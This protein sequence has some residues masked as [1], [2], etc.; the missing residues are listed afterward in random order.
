M[1][2]NSVLIVALLGLM[3]IP[4]YAQQSKSSVPDT[5]AC[6]STFAFG[7]GLTYLSFCVTA[8]GNV[9]YLTSP[10]GYQHFGGTEGYSLCDAGTGNVYWDYAAHGDDAAWGAPTVTQPN[11]P[12]TFPLT[13]KR[14]TV[15]GIFTLTQKFTWNTAEHIVAVS[16]TVKNNL[17]VTKNLY[18]TR[19]TDADI[20]NCSNSCHSYFMSNDQ[21]DMAWGTG[22]PAPDPYALMLYTTSPAIAHVATFDAFSIGIQTNAC[23]IPINQTQEF[24]FDAV[25]YLTHNFSLPAHASKTINVEY[26][27]Y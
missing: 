17:P 6:Q 7:S 12:N 26:K 4:V 20:D 18:L 9:L 16:M 8:N 11:G 5:A 19:M 21:T 22:V 10:Q 27:R 1:F 15:D 24:F 2:R 3:A 14:T 23:S 13:I 25:F